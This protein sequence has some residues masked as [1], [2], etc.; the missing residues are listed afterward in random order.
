MLSLL[1]CQACHNW[2]TT[3]QYLHTM[4]STKLEKV[5]DE[6]CLYI[7]SVVNDVMSRFKRHA[8]VT[9]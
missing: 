8:H 7:F 5:S 2:V 3:I 1:V 9:L 4:S 6:S